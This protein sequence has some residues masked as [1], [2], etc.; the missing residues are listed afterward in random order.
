MCHSTNQYYML[1]KKVSS[2]DLQVP[3]SVIAHM[4]GGRLFQKYGQ[5]Q[6]KHSCTKACS[7][8]SVPLKQDGSNT[9]KP[10]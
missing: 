8:T 1:N 10:L 5:Q 9:M 3:E 4:S 6:Q 7:E 2:L